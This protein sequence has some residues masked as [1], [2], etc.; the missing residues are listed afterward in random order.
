MLKQLVASAVALAAVP[1]MA[2][3]GP[4]T[5]PIE[6]MVLGT[7]HFGNPGRDINNVKAD[8]VLTP[9]RQAELARLAK[10]LAAFHPTHVVI[11]HEVDSPDLS[12][13]DYANFSDAMLAGKADESVQIGYRTARLAG[14]TTVNGIDEQPKADEP[15]Y[16]P[17]ENLQQVAAKFGETNMLAKAN[18]PVA[19]WSK[20]FEAAQKTKSIAQ[21]LTEMNSPRSING[22][23]D[24][25]YGVLA[26]GDR[27]AQPGADLN[28][29]WYLRNAKIFGKLMQI[30]KPG[31]RVLVIY[32][33]G[34]LF[35]LR[36]FASLTPGYRSVD[37]LPY[38]AKAAR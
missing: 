11:E 32:G 5:K 29:M 26:V 3:D 9:K 19:A 36:H 28:A 27:D 38:L 18:A 15:D 35:W 23:M 14:L 8:L 7:Y 22:R 24:S 6:V 10:A 33:A 4:T 16:F 21:L 30:A 34:H 2:A 12:V 31:D 25:Y 1:V 17:Y 37:V 20:S 13:E